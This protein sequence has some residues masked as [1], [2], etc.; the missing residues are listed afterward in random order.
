[1]FSRGNELHHSNQQQQMLK[2]VWTRL[3]G[4]TKKNLYT[5]CVPSV[6]I[7]I[8]KNATM[9][10]YSTVIVVVLLFSKYFLKSQIAFL[11]YRTLHTHSLHLHSLLAVNKH[12]KTCNSPFK[13][14][15]ILCTYEGKCSRDQFVYMVLV[16][17]Y[18]IY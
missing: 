2:D 12:K 8:L 7:K 11:H 10:Y 6:I 17:I 9:L 18:S 3:T 4:E 5:I 1:M 13:S 16:L 15:E 14:F